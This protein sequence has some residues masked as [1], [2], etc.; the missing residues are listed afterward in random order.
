MMKA[1]AASK[2]ARTAQ[3]REIEHWQL[4]FD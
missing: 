1:G 2:A 3:E 4:R